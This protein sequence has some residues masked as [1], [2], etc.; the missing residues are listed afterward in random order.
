[1]KIDGVFGKGTAAWVSQ[2]ETNNGFAVDGIAD[3]AVLAVLGID[4]STITLKLGTKHATVATAQ[5]ALA[6]VLKVKVKADGVF[7]SGTLRL[8]K[9]FQKTVGLKQSGVINHETWMALLSASSQQ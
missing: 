5:T 2:L 3:D 9:R 7:G 1:M 4:P 6:R 8:V